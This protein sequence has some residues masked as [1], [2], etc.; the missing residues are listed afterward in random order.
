ML[1][2]GY[3]LILGTA[4]LLRIP[5]SGS[6]ASVKP[7]FSWS[8]RSVFTAVHSCVHICPRGNTYLTLWKTP[9]IG[10]RSGHWVSSGLREGAPLQI[11][12]AGSVSLSPLKW[13]HHPRECGSRREIVRE[14]GDCHLVRTEATALRLLGTQNLRI[15]EHAWRLV[16]GPPSDMV[17]LASSLNCWHIY[18]CCPPRGPESQDSES[19]HQASGYCGPSLFT[20]TYQ[21]YV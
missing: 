21:R 16:L 1:L 17:Y 7:K 10:S 18:L 9:E 19:K 11:Q 14:N 8:P 2:G 4:D 6:R 15:R 20:Q 3:D 12:V 5:T 13:P